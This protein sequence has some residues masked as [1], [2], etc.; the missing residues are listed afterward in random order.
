MHISSVI[1]LVSIFC[2]SYLMYNLSYLILPTIFFTPLPVPVWFLCCIGPYIYKR[3]ILKS[4]I[5]ED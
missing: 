2:I 1:N 3:M 5:K 4:N